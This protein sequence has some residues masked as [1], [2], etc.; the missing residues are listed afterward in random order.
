MEGEVLTKEEEGSIIK[1]P[2]V[3]VRDGKDY[4]ETATR[5]EKAANGNTS[6]FHK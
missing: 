4:R 2:V 3:D 5:M 1:V 6:K